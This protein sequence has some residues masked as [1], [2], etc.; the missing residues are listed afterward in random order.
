MGARYKASSPMTVILLTMITRF[1][2]RL[3]FALAVEPLGHSGAWLATA[4]SQLVES[5]PG[6]NGQSMPNWHPPSVLCSAMGAV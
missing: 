3:S 4:D 5:L 1:T 2:V 6:D